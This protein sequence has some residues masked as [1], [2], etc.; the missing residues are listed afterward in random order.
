MLA[1]VVAVVPLLAALGLAVTAQPAQPQPTPGEPQP[2]PTPPAEPAPPARPTFETHDL[3]ID[4]VARRY[5]L[6]VPPTLTDAPRPVVFS[7]HGTMGSGANGGTPITAE[8]LK[9]GHI[10]IAPDALADSRGVIQWNM[11][12]SRDRHQPSSDVAAVLAMLDD[13]SIKHAIDRTRVYATGFSSGGGMCYMLAIEAPRHFAAIAP[14]AGGMFN[15]M[16]PRD[17]PRIAV[18][19]LI[20]HGTADSIIPWDG[21]DRGRRELSRSNELLSVDDVFKLWARRNGSDDDHIAELT[22]PDLTP[23]DGCRVTRFTAPADRRRIERKLWTAETV[24]LKVEGGGHTWS[25]AVPEGSRA[26]NAP[27]ATC[28]DLD[29]AATILDFFQRFQRVDDESIDL[30]EP[31]ELAPT[32]QPA[33]PTEARP[34]P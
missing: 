2:A 26:T 5:H 15:H 4:G 34:Q 20:Y 19:M 23:T 10:V 11:V 24:L 33:K 29:L 1:T 9:R 8:A 3:T 31:A 32:P 27:A 13:V 12:R 14:L 25:Y 28:L 7:F 30:A 16:A 21:G 17:T 22:L 6:A 18:P